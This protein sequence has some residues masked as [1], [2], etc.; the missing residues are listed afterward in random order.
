[1]TQ[2]PPKVR[3]SGNMISSLKKI[4]NTQT[5]RRGLI[6]LAS[7][8]MM[9]MMGFASFDTVQAD[10]NNLP[11]DAQPLRVPMSPTRSMQP[12][13]ANAAPADVAPVSEA[14]PPSETPQT[15]I[16]APVGKPIVRI[17]F[18]SGD[19]TLSDDA[20]D[21][22][23]NFAEKFRVNGGRVTLQGYAGTT[24]SSSS[25]DRRLSLRRVLAVREMIMTAGISPERLEVRAL[26]GAKDA[27]PLDR[28]DILKPGR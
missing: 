13:T 6:I 3:V 5:R 1:M 11:V 7:F 4:M 20:R 18:D 12:D 21:K 22:I 28:V 8:V 27:G 10:E 17:L 9:T 24:G 25:N 16:T 19:A 15:A 23:L 26:G 2:Q 14:S